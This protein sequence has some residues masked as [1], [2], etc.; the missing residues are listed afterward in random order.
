MFR[1]GEDGR[2]LAML[3]PASEKLNL[4]QPMGEMLPTPHLASRVPTTLRALCLPALVAHRAPVHTRGVPKAAADPAPW[5]LRLPTLGAGAEDVPGRWL[6]GK[7]KTTSCQKVT[8]GK[9]ETCKT[10]EPCYLLS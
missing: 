6:K 9:A 1:L 2:V 5:K 8:A 10:F 3:G 7:A 4:K